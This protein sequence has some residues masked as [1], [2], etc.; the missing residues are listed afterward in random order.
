MSFDILYIS[1][2]SN[3]RFIPFRGLFPLRPSGLV[4]ERSLVLLFELVIS[5]ASLLI[6]VPFGLAFQQLRIF[7]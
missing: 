6:G 3:F 1:L 7:I 5:R 2:Y 4:V